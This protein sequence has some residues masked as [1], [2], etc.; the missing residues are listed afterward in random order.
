[1]LF[2]HEV[3]GMKRRQL[4]KIS[5]GVID[6]TGAHTVAYQKLPACQKTG[7]QKHEAEKHDIHCWKAYHVFSP[8][9][10]SSLQKVSVTIRLRSGA[11]GLK[12]TALVK[13]IQKDSTSKAHTYRFTCKSTIPG[14]EPHTV[15]RRLPG[16]KLLACAEK[17]YEC[18]S[19][20]YFHSRWKIGWTICSELAPILTGRQQ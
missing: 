3:G 8:W 6:G 15:V 9:C 14:C 2:S 13:S 18:T 20:L 1:M 17:T 5:S 10:P 19:C 11:I 12:S 7:Q 4:M 16:Q